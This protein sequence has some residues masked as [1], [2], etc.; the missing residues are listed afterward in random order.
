VPAKRLFAILTIA[1]VIMTAAAALA[2]YM[3]IRPGSESKKEAQLALSFKPFTLQELLTFDM[4][5][6]SASC[7]RP[8][9]SAK[10][11]KMEKQVAEVRELPLKKSIT[12][13]SC[14]EAGVRAQ[15]NESISRQTPAEELEA[16]RKLL[17]ALGLVKPEENLKQTLTN[18]YTEQIAGSYN[19]E[20]KEITVVEGK[21]LGTIM[22]ELTIVHEI[23]HALQDQN[24]HLDRPPL[25]NEAYSGD[26]N[27][28]IESLAEGDAMT[29]MLDY[30]KEYVDMAKLLK[31]EL[32]G[33]EGSQVSSEQLDRAP[34]YI[35]RSLL[36]PYEEGMVF[37]I[38]LKER[39]GIAGIDAAF[40][41]P[42]LSS[43]QI[44]HPDKYIGR[45]DNPRTVPLADISGILGKKWKMINSDTLGEFDVG[46]W[47]EQLSGMIASRD[48]AGGWG[49][50]TIQYYRGPGGKYVVVNAF[51]WDTPADARQFFDGYA[52]LIED[53]FGKKA[54]E[55]EASPA[56]DVW[57][58]DGEYFY[59]GLAGDGTLC[60]QAPDRATLDLVL[61]QFPN[62]P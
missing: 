60:I 5:V 35:R 31:E 36:F 16:D 22:D 29:A 9:R 32:K 3:V 57:K 61:R 27:L 45:R 50:N 40:A 24:F 20:D 4:K 62:Y 11:S 58:A 2:V 44:M 52:G 15:I 37:V 47:F 13:R 17:V 8:I 6:D 33:L 41:D 49:G 7:G 48:V 43:E 42:P 23:T 56:R 25:D 14:S 10:L 55:V 51:V 59:S 39:K 53:R 19:E 26:N 1:V 18:V 30:A 28:A 38:A 54:G 34:L 12:F 46:V 21:G